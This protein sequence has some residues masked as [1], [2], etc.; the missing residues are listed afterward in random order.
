MPPRSNKQLRVVLADKPD[1]VQ[2]AIH[3]YMPGPTFASPDRIRFRCLNTI[4]GGSFTSRLNLNLREDK[5]YT[6]GASSNYAMR[7]ATGYFVATAD[8]QGEHT[9]AALKEFMAEFARI[10]SGDITS[11]EVEKTRTTNRME[12]IQSFQELSH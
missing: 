2:T 9:A 12:R 5:G 3:W 8:V 1:S 4:L 10:R 11:E 7:P 6:Y